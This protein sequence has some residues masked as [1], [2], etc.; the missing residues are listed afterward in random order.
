[1]KKL[2]SLALLLPTIALAQE[3]PNRSAKTFYGTQACDDVMSMTNTVVGKYGEQPLF[4]GMGIQ[5]SAADGKGYAGSMMMFV[6]QDT[7]SWSLITLYG[8]GTG[9]MVASGKEFEPYGGPRIT[10][11]EPPEPKLESQAYKPNLPNVDLQ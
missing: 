10:I 5:F 4:K 2:I 8:D 9:C 6:N 7:G 1:M 3:T 11:Q